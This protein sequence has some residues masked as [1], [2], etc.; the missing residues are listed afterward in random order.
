MKKKQVQ[1]EVCGEVV[2]VEKDVAQ[3]WGVI[4]DMYENS[5][6]GEIEEVVPLKEITDRAIFDKLVEWTTRYKDRAYS[7]SDEDRYNR[8]K[9]VHVYEPEDKR[10]LPTDEENLFKLMHAAYSLQ[11]FDLFDL[12]CEVVADKLNELTV[13]QIRGKE[14]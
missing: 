3:K 2:S 7:L 9:R 11:C 1:F 10:W 5:Q 8:E 12:T 4:A 14:G 13:E 6:T